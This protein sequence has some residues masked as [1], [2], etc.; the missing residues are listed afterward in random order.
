VSINE[1]PKEKGQ[2][3]T[4][5]KKADRKKEMAQMGELIKKNIMDQLIDDDR[6][7]DSKIT[8]EVRNGTVTLKGEVPTYFSKN[9]AHEDARHIWRVRNVR[10]HLKV[11]HPP[12]MPIP[13]DLEIEEF[14]R[15]R[16]AANPDI[17]LMDIIVKVRAG[18]ITRL[19]VQK[20]KTARGL[21]KKNEIQRV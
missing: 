14:I 4:P 17:D 12:T 2:S 19:R 9:L 11:N 21:A 18:R 5:M 8:V 3:T 10:N 20:N 13:M 15:N 6:I 7:D 16:F 1:K